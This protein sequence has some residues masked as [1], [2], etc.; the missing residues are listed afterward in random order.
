MTKHISGLGEIID[1]FVGILI[2]Q[3]GVLHD[4][5]T[6]FAEALPCLRKI[7]G[8]GLPVVA[9]TNSGRMKGPNRQRLNRFGF[10]EDL[11]GEVIT[12][13]MV[14]RARITDMLAAGDLVPGDKVLNL[15]RENDTTV[16]DGS[17]LLPSDDPADSIR[18]VLISGLSPEEI[19]RETY[20][21]MLSP[22]ARAG[23][24]AICANPD[25]VVYADGKAAFGPGRVAQDYE[26][27]G[28]GVTYAGKPGPEIFRR[29]LAVLG[30]PDPGRVLMIGDS[31]HHDIAGAAALGCRTLLI[32]GGVQALSAAEGVLPD[33]SLET[34]RF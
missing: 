28:G 1:H 12:S 4:G 32:A 25:H 11:I 3:F 13:G 2:D 14:A 22:L 16:L 8:V 9:I 7:A 18:L 15:T 34:L 31:H 20:R 27:E 24:P 29:S 21:Q 6:V 17:G 10:T 5:K 33:Y 23:I 19:T 30:D 26:D